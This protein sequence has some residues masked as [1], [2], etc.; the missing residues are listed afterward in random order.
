MSA[1]SLLDGVG[2][3]K[4]VVKTFSRLRLRLRPAPN[5]HGKPRSRF[6]PVV[7]TLPTGWT[8]EDGGE[9]GR[10]ETYSVRHYGATTTNSTNI[11]RVEQTVLRPGAAVEPRR[12]RDHIVFGDFQHFLVRLGSFP[13]T[14]ETRTTS[15]PSIDVR[16][17][18]PDPNEKFRTICSSKSKIV[19][20]AF[21]YAIT[22][23][24]PATTTLTLFARREVQ[25][26]V[27]FLRYNP[28]PPFGFHG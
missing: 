1:G 14:Q 6:R 12:R 9:G 22:R 23:L 24:P 25:L 21:V 28:P 11:T 15:R 4:S 18:A 19:H 5:V 26:F 17:V 27:S 10:G 16:F 2:T 7:A 13:A 20:T 3:R 8:W